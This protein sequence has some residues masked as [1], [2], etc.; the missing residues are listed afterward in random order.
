SASSLNIDAVDYAHF[1]LDYRQFSA[2]VT[3]NYFRRDYKRTCELVFPDA[4]WHVDLA[5]NT[6]TDHAGNCLFEDSSSIAD[7]YT[8]QMEHFLAVVAGKSASL[9]TF[10]D[11]VAVLKIAM[12]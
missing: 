8:A 4:T 3:L 10:E 11:G 2:S 9:N 12:K 1:L 6:I 7:T 5:A